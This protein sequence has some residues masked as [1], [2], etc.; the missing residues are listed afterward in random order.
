MLGDQPWAV[1]DA[2]PGGAQ[3][4]PQLPADVTDGHRVLALADRDSGVAVHPGPQHDPGF[5]RLGR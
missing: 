3:Q 4:H 2:D 5:E 1:V